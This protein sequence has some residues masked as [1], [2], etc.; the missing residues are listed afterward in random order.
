[1]EGSGHGLNEFFSW[2]LHS[3][4]KK[5][6]IPVKIASDSADVHSELLM[7]ARLRAL[8]LDQSVELKKEMIDKHVGLIVE[9][10]T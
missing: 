1:L 5:H 2:C 8:P 3:I 10:S 7:N 9:K 6:E 4:E